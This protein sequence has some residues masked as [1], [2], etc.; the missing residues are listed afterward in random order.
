MS[1]KK[2]L[3]IF[4]ALSVVLLTGIGLLPKSVT[5][6]T[7]ETAVTTTTSSDVH[8]TQTSDPVPVNET[9]AGWTVTVKE[10]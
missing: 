5:I 6:P 1:D 10:Y 3:I 4:I 7:P 9:T 2:A 8:V